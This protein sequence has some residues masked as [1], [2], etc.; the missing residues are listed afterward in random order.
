MPDCCDGGEGRV[1]EGD[2]QGGVVWGDGDV[3]GACSLALTSNN[4]LVELMESMEEGWGNL[5]LRSRVRG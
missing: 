2:A 5:P 3:Q 4:A 1:L